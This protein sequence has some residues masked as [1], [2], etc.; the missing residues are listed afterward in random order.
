LKHANLDCVE[1]HKKDRQLF[2][3]LGL[4]RCGTSALTKAL[5]TCGAGLEFQHPG[6]ANGL[7]K[8]DQWHPAGGYESYEIPPVL[9]LVREIADRVGGS[10]GNPVI[11]DEVTLSVTDTFAVAGLLDAIPSFPFAIKDPMLTFQYRQWKEIARN[12]GI[13]TRAVV[14]L[15]DPLEGAHALLKRRFCRTIRGGLEMWLRY[16]AEVQYLAEAGEDPLIVLYDGDV[17]AY[18]PQIEALCV[19]TG[20]TFDREK[21]REGF[22]PAPRQEYDRGEIDQHPL[23]D[24]IR[25]LFDDLRSRRLEQRPQ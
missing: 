5:A 22:N 19:A 14:S 11:G 25:G 8:T 15:R 17:E 1:L 7:W 9:L 4:N 16:Y 2:L 18:L 23:A 21:V 6:L 12:A 3:I 13:E 20:L 24:A 10:Q